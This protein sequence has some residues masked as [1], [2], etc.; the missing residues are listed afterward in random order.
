MLQKRSLFHKQQ[1][2]FQKE[3]NNLKKVRFSLFSSQMIEEE[4]D[5]REKMCK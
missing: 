4:K 3:K 1:T 5:K 2:L